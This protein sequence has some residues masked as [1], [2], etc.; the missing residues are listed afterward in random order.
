MPRPSPICPIWTNLPNLSRQFV[1][2]PLPEKK[3]IIV[4]HIWIL[5][6]LP[7]DSP[8]CLQ[9]LYSFGR[10]VFP[11]WQNRRSSTRRSSP[12]P[13]LS[14]AP[15]CVSI[16]CNG[17]LHFF[18][19]GVSFSFSWTGPSLSDLLGPV[20]RITNFLSPFN[21]NVFVRCVTVPN[22]TPTLCLICRRTVS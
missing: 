3:T 10:S 19:F 12:S 5:A 15:S 16:L 13:N 18:W 22:N 20:R 9:T 6:S 21:P 8:Y 11:L 4:N 14:W 1:L 7:I 2:G 17:L